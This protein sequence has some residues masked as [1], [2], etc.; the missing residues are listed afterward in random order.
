[1]W[2]LNGRDKNKPLSETID[3]PASIA[4]ALR[5]AAGEVQ[6]AGRGI[7]GYGAATSAA[8][9]Q[10]DHAAAQ[11]D[12]VAVEQKRVSSRS[13]VRR[14]L[15]AA[16]AIV[17]CIAAAFGTY[18]LGLRHHAD[19]STSAEAAQ[20]P[21][22]STT[23]VSLEQLARMARERTCDTFAHAYSSLPASLRAQGSPPTVAV[24]VQRF[25]KRT[26][27]GVATDLAEILNSDLGPAYR[28]QHWPAWLQAFDNYVAALRA[29]S[30]IETNAANSQ[31]RADI[32]TLYQRAL[33]EPIQICGVPG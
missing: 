31:T 17:T 5:R 25:P 10:L 23:S 28:Q 16:A 6:A 20:P 26:T 11:L 14:P 24:P 19:S 7:P 9:T 13:R 21:R 8:V 1:M 15:A 12:T 32:M 22:L 27:H 3:T 2:D 29:V 4:T 30:F 18:Q 33:I